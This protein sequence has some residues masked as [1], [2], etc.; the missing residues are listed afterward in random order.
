[1]IFI[2]RAFV[3]LLNYGDTYVIA[4]EGLGLIF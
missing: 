1:M 4:T 2:G 3:R